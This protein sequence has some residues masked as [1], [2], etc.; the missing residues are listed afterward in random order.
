MTRPSRD[1][2]DG[3]ARLLDV[4]ESGT[5]GINRVLVGIHLDPFLSLR[6]L[7]GYCGLSVRTLRG[8][9][10]HPNRPLPCYRVGGKLLVRRSEF[11][12]W[13]LHFK[14]LP[15]EDLDGVVDDILRDL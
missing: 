7:S 13:M 12:C 2:H 9:L 11:D 15:R 3:A 6:A 14:R 10:D 4:H 5:Q 1:R 8:Y